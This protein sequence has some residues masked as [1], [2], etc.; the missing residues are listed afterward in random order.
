[1]QF[2]NNSTKYLELRHK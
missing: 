2:Q 1:M